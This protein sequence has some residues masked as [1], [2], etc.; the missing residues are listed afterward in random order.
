[1]EFSVPTAVISETV[2]R[3]FNFI[4]AFTR[5]T[6][7]DPERLAS[8]LTQHLT[9]VA[10]WSERTQ[11]FD[12]ASAKD[13]AACTTGL[14]ISSTPRRMRGKNTDLAFQSEDDILATNNNTIILGDPGSGKTTTLK[15]IAHK[16]FYESPST[17]EDHFQFPV[18][19]RL[20]VV[21]HEYDSIFGFLANVLG[22]IADDS[23]PSDHKFD[24]EYQAR[25]VNRRPLD[26]AVCSYLNGARA[27]LMIDGLDEVPKHKRDQIERELSSLALNAYTYKLVCTCRSGAY[28]HIQG[29]D[30][31]ELLPLTKAQRDEV[32]EN[33]CS[34]PDSFR[35]YAEET[36]YEMLLDRPLFLVQV[37]SVFE[38]TERLPDKPSDVCLRLVDLSIRQWDE[39][40][41]IK[42]ELAYSSFTSEEKRAFL[43][44]FAFELHFSVGGSI[45]SVEEMEKTYL[46]LN[47]E[48]DLPADE[49]QKVIEELEHHTGLFVKAFFDAYEFCHLTI[50]E[51]L[52]GEYI[53]T[54]PAML[55]VAE[56]LRTDPAPV[57]VAV[58][59]S[60]SS[61]LWFAALVLKSAGYDGFLGETKFNAE[62]LVKRLLLENPR[63]RSDPIFGYA[64]IVFLE[65]SDID[66]EIVNDFL[67]LRNVEASIRQ[68]INEKVYVKLDEK[69]SELKKRSITLRW[70]GGVPKGMPLETVNQ[71][72][73]SSDKLSQ[74]LVSTG[75]SLRLIDEKYEIEEFIDS[76]QLRFLRRIQIH[77]DFSWMPSDQ[78]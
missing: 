38:K 39:E 49:A 63:F 69:Y 32:I 74:Y 37:I 44:Q 68:A 20:R 27:L 60:R 52:A 8:E 46:K 75:S 41:G 28:S 50:Q 43:S 2:K 66:E 70:L 3:T 11:M 30:S 64:V 45:F 26:A 23:K 17:P 18:L 59:I 78:I 62:Y 57:A 42:R 24:N 12:M 61:S 35:A 6:G 21:V 36:S 51:C 47:D 22:I 7:Q 10:N 53:S 58:A 67:K 71:F 14:R 56:F 48:F 13:T 55:N 76:E 1:M 73:V 25:K 34:E 77:G 31:C 19:I 15:R 4:D 16:L 33:W 54:R 65:Y 72:K 40:R 29:F 5:S 9:Y